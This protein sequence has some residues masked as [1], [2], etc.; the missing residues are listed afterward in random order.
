VTPGT[1]GGERRFLVALAGVSA[2]ALGL[3]LWG[4]AAAPLLSDDV[5]SAVS[6]VSFVERGHIGTT[7]WHHPHLRDLLLYA[8]LALFGGSKLAL[9]GVSVAFG[10]GTVWLLGLVARRLLGSGRVALL[11]ALLLATDA[12][13]VD[14]SRQA[15]HENYM[16]FFTLL[17]LWLVLRYRDDLR[18]RWLVAAGVAFGLGVASKWVVGAVILATWAWQA[19]GTLRARD[20]HAVR[21]AAFETAALL[22][23]PFAV[24]LAVFAPWFAAGNDLQ[25]LVRLTFAM[26]RENLNHPGGNP[27]QVAVLDHR[28]WTWF[29]KPIAWADF[30]LDGGRPVVLA[31][32]TNP[33]AWLLTLPAI[34]RLAIVGRRDARPG[35]NAIVGLFLVSY[36][37]FV[38][39]PR[40]IF[41]NS[42]LNV[43]PF[44]AMAVADLVFA[45]GRLFGRERRIVAAY[46]AV[47]VVTSAPLYL[48]ATGAWAAVPGL[49]GVVESLRPPPEME[50]R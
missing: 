13:H 3:R 41:A 4:L 16:A 8:S 5:H 29:V 33:V 28:A 6:A 47:L 39:T 36:V 20:E 26:L 46:V 12:L 18:A 37:P 1:G 7:M 49:E 40:P 42:A 48:L 2:L 27:Y 35:A 22:A 24:Y 43:L 32:I 17:G 31:A 10:A 15:V 25:G 45:A 11:A 34:L 9:A 50:G 38:L 19:W 21:R 44:A 30:T 14:F 23:L